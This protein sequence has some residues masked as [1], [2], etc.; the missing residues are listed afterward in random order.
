[1]SISDEAT[2]IKQ[3]AAVINA[4]IPYQQNNCLLEGL[5]KLSPR[6]STRI[7]RII[8]EE[9]IRLTALTDTP[10]D[11]SEF[12]IFPVSKF[13]HFGISMRLD[14]VGKDILQRETSRYADRYTVGVFESVMNSDYYQSHIKREQQQ[15]IVKAFTVESQS[16][17]DL[18]FGEDLAVRPNFTVS[19]TQFDKGRNAVIASLSRSTMVLETKRMPS[20]ESEESELTFHFPE[21]PGLVTNDGKIDYVLDT[22]RFNRDTHKFETVFTLAPSSPKQVANKLAHYLS[23]IVNKQP[24]QRELEIER[25][26]QDLERDRILFYSPWIPIFLGSSDRGIAPEFALLTQANIAANGGFHIIDQLPGGTIFSRLLKELETFGETFLLRGLFQTKNGPLQV[27]AT[28]RELAAIKM[29][30]QFIEM[31][32]A[33]GNFTILQCRL[34]PVKQS[35]VNNALDIHDMVVTDYPELSALTHTLFCRNITKWIG[36][37]AINEPQERKA[38]PKAIIDQG[39][40]WNIKIIMEDDIDRRSEPRYLMNRSAS[41]KQGLFSSIDGTLN[42]LSQSGLK[43]TLNTPPAEFKEQTLKVTVP[44]IKI[45]NETYQIIAYD[46]VTGVLRLAIPRAKDN[47][48]A[49]KVASMVDTNPSYFKQRDVALHQRNIHRFLWEIAA[50]NCP[51]TAVLTTNHRH[52]LDRLKTV[53]VSGQGKDMAPFTVIENQAYLHGFFADK[54]AS[55]P[56]SPL[57]EE[58]LRK[59]KGEAQLVH[60]VRKKDKR[61]IYVPKRDYLFGSVRQQMSQRVTEAEIDVFVTHIT[62]LYCD[63]ATTPLTNKRLAQLSK[64]DVDAYEKLKKA[65]EAYT[66]VITLTNLSALHAALLRF[67]ISPVEEATATDPLGNAKQQLEQVKKQH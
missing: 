67:G 43:I 41:I 49:E 51:F 7:R 20:I 6:L 55:K 15:K 29:F 36:K 2:I 19:C 35:D 56:C 58:L 30:N 23:G 4:L 45:K 53:Y 11:N 37:L 22:I 46:A 63:S 18:D 38:F 59:P 10:A 47:S 9:V 39:A 28:F 57:L 64:L 27:A 3:H 65:Q 54:K 52:I 33:T 31:I 14:R 44:D 40:E 21:I 60:A 17:D 61:I 25:A 12:A 16:F 26:M 1:M 8:K 62:S 66:H 13:K 50:R 5:N 42:D 48:A 24:L 34:A 32:M